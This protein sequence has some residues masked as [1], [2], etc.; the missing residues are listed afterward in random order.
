MINEMQCDECGVVEYERS[1][2][3]PLRDTCPLCDRPAKR[4]ISE[5]TFRL[6]GGGWAGNGYASEPKGNANHSMVSV[7]GGRTWEGPGNARYDYAD[8]GSA[9]WCEAYGKYTD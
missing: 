9:N 7:D 8:Q 4:L 5:C 3:D 2:K 6:L 1:I